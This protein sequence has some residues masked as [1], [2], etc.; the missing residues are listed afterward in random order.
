MPRLILDPEQVRKVLDNLILNAREAVG[1]GRRNS[2]GHLR[3]GRLGF[4]MGYRQWLRNVQGVHREV[5]LSSI[6]NDK[7]AGD[8]DRS[9]PQQDDRGSPQGKDRSGERGRQRKRIQS[10]LP[11]REIE[12]VGKGQGVGCRGKEKRRR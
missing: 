10:Y 6:Q 9:L 2:S 5:P 12:G 7:K 3:E 11:S 8:G 1:D 4:D